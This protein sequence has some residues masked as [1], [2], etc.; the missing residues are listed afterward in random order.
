MRQPFHLIDSLANG[1]TAI[2]RQPLAILFSIGI[3]AYLW[4]GSAI[5]LTLPEYSANHLLS[6]SLGTLHAVDA[7]ALLVVTNLIPALTPGA[8]VDTLPPPIFL[9]ARAFVAAVCGLNLAALALSSWFLA[10]LRHVVFRER[11]SLRSMFRHTTQLTVRLGIVFV[12]IGGAIAPLLIM[13]GLLA[14]AVPTALPLIFTGWIALALI[15]LV[16]LG[17]TPEVIA[18]YRCGPLLAIRRSLHFARQRWLAIATFLAVCA[19]IEVGFGAIWRALASQPG[20]LM[21]ALVGHAWISSGLRAARLA[22]YR[23][24]AATLAPLSP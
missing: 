16:A 1:Y 17:F 5:N 22:F 23:S 2:Y 24:H 9:E 4:L 7:R 20:W 21:P 19:V 11:G 12:I 14:V 18:I 6:Q 3:S 10:T 8:N 15:G 13:S